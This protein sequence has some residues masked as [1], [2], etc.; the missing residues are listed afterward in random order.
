[1]VSWSSMRTFVIPF[2]YNKIWCK[3]VTTS[4]RKPVFFSDTNFKHHLSH[5]KTLNLERMQ[6]LLITRYDMIRSINVK[7]TITPNFI[8]VFSFF[9]QDFIQYMFFLSFVNGKT[10]N[11]KIELQHNTFSFVLINF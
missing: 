3:I 5:V 10:V 1:M 6:I 8:S 11:M 9:F 2:H 7:Y 4:V